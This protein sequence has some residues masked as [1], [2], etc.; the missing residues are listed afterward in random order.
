MTLTMLCSTRV[1]NPYESPIYRPYPELLMLVAFHFVW[2][3]YFVWLALRVSVLALSKRLPRTCRRHCGGC[4]NERVGVFD[5]GYVVIRF[6]DHF[7]WDL[8]ECGP[9]GP[10]PALEQLG[11]DWRLEIVVWAGFDSQ[12]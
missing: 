3:V 1:P 9:M 11:A 4:R 6:Q 7:P 12:P 2:W 5:V 8:H 10:S